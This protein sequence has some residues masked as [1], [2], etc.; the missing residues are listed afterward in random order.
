MADY[1][2]GLPIR[3]EADGAD[4]RVQV[5][6]VDKT[7]PNTQQT[8]VDTDS[9]L[10][11]EA[12][13]NDPAGVDRVTRLSELGAV[14]PDGQYDA[15]NNTKPGN[16]GLIASQRNVTP[17]DT[18]Q[19]QRLTAVTNG[20]KRL[21]D[22]SLHDENG[23]VFSE[24]NPL[25]ISWVDSEGTEVNDYNTAAN[26]AGAGASNH[27]YTTAAAFK[28]SQINATAS[29]KM[30]I[31]VQVE[32]GAGTAVFTTKFVAFNSTANTNIEL[33]LKEPIS[34]ASGV[35]VRVIRTN[36]D[37]QPQ[38]VYSTISGHEVT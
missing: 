11:V 29:G 12:H 4:E 21:L 35:I 36:K 30:K 28:L 32:T 24:A 3:S 7:N 9:N 8:T 5:K 33:T 14:T 10:H 6:I 37:N 23:A 34:V 20:T 16:V 2:S 19:T 27:D 13:G 25:P 1:N 31:E 18:T 15:A 38:D 26:V 17:G 22:V